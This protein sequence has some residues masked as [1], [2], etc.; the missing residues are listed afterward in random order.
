MWVR[1]SLPLSYIPRN[2]VVCVKLDAQCKVSLIL[3]PS[4]LSYNTVSQTL[5]ADHGGINL[6]S[7]VE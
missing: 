3:M 5:A 6:T 4:T 7:V 1:W 2:F